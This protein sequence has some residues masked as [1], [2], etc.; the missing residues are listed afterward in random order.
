[1]ADVHLV[2]FSPGHIELRQN[3]IVLKPMA[4]ELSEKL[5]AWTGLRWMVV[6]S[7]ERGDPTLEEQAAEKIAAK[8][9][10]AEDDPLVRQVLKTFPDAAI[11]GL[12]ESGD[13]DDNS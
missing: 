10:A 6:L 13:S 11:S 9:R 2:R 4:K 12:R 3:E 1:M 5:Q 7:E 8:L